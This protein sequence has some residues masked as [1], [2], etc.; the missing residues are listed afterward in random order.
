[1]YCLPADISTL[2]ERPGANKSRIVSLYIS[3]IDACV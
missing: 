3:N 1:V 2:L